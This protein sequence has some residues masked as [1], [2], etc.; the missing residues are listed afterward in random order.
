MLRFT[1]FTWLL[2]VAALLSL[3][4]CSS[5]APTDDPSL[6]YTKIWQTVQAAQ[7]QTRKFV[8]PTPAFTETPFDTITPR[9]TH[10]PLLS[11]TPIPGVSSPTGSTVNTSDTP[12]STRTPRAA[13]QS[14]SC[15]NA[16]FLKDVTYPDG[17]DLPPGTTFVKTW[18]FAN[19]GPCTWTTDYQL[20]FSYVSDTGKNGVFNPPPRVNFPTKV[21][22]GQNM[23]ISVNLRA[24]MKKGTYQVVFV[25]QNDKGY[26]IP[27]VNE[28]SYEFFV[29]FVVK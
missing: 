17:S 29:L 9:A 22:P 13:T 18:S 27:L 20:V 3:E 2:M 14:V 6:A 11:S 23:E 25:L 7:T 28:K 16:N 15:D 5:G 26:S 19:L 21:L 10:T 1:I 24:P 8:S 12:A 4:A